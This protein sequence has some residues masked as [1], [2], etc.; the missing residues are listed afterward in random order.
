MSGPDR[1]TDE[2]ALYPE[3]PAEG[4]ELRKGWTTGACAAAATRAAAEA[5]LTGR[6]PDPVTITLPRGQTPSFILARCSRTANSATAGVVKDAGDDPDVTHGALVLSTVERS[7]PGRGVVFRAGEGVG[8]V[9]RAGLPLAVGEPA[10]NPAPRAQI[11]A[12]L[13]DAVRAAGGDPAT[14]DFVV[15]IAIPGGAKLAERTLNGRLGIVGGLSVL[16]TSG[17]VVPYSCAAWIHSIH[18]GIDVARAAGLSHIAASTGSTSEAAVKVLYALDDAALI[19]MGDF[20]GGTLK[21]LR[22]HPTPR[23]TIAGG[24]AKLAKLAAGELDL[25]SG[26]SQVD[27]AKLAALLQDLAAPAE[28]VSRATAAASAGE[29]LQIA[30]AAG[31]RLADAVA[32]RARATAL[33]TLAGGI[34]VDVLV[35]DRQGTLIGRAGP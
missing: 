14:L 16:G 12:A 13:A 7:G 33:A 23:L 26:R 2:A 22:N 6:F 10:I 5:L 21:Y 18:R 1:D 25:H 32:E 4:R 30:T 28:T 8:T 34:A 19:D 27:G 11:G 17:I 20:A 31:V 35:F 3:P 24:F 15:T 29:V 9:T